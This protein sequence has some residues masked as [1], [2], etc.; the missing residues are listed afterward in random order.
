LAARVSGRL[1]KVLIEDGMV[2]K[3]G[4]SVAL[5]EDQELQS[6]R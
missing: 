5:I 3:K 1:E 4:A 6:R 2:V